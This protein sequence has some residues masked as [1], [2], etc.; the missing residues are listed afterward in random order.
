M[1]RCV[2]CNSMAVV[3]LWGRWDQESAMCSNYE[4]IGYASSIFIGSSS[5]ENGKMRYFLIR[6]NCEL[7]LYRKIVM[8]MPHYLKWM[9]FN[10]WM[11]LFP[12]SL[13]HSPLLET[14]P[15]DQDETS[16]KS[17]RHR[18]G[19][20]KINATNQRLCT[21]VQRL[22]VGHPE[23]PGVF[24]PDGRWSR[25][26]CRRGCRPTG[27]LSEGIHITLCHLFGVWCPASRP[28]SVVVGAL[29][30]NLPNNNT[31]K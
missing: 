1:F 16:Y 30:L 12:L 15:Q 28:V 24:R 9:P 13:T 18:S 31:T 23:H 20:R 21:W 19:H 25:G 29:P 10:I 11:F 6:L 5:P 14:S 8:W 17:H 3:F 27:S 26:W 2:L 7:S 4:S 22:R